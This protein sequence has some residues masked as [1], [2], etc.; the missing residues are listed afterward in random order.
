MKSD[1]IRVC[2]VDD[3]KILSAKLKKEILSNFPDQ[4]FEFMCFETGE[5]CELYHRGEADI[6]IVDY[7][8][9]SRCRNAKN[10]IEV[11]DW[12]R[13]TCPDTSTILF[14]R[15]EHTGLALEALQH[16]ALDYVVKNEMMFHRLNLVL[17][18]LLQIRDLRFDLIRQKERGFVALL[19]MI[20]LLAFATA[21]QFVEG[22]IALNHLNPLIHLP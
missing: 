17:V 3:D 5:H 21:L 9:N 1:L 16:G 2:I 10:G 18:R 7:H 8:L 22:G 14:T 19:I 12:F 13:E 6:A 15:E 4:D 11:I 20:F